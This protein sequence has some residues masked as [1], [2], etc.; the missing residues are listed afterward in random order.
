MDEYE[1]LATGGYGSV[2]LN[3]ELQIV[4]K[5][6]PK[7]TDSNG[8]QILLYSTIV[9]LA[10]HESLS[11]I[12][13]VPTLSS[14]DTTN[15]SVELY[16]PFYGVPLNQYLQS[17]PANRRESF[18]VDII[19]Q[20]VD[21]CIQLHENGLQHTDLKPANI[22]VNNSEIV[23][24]IDFNIVSTLI[25]SETG[26]LRW[27]ESIGTWNYTAPEIILASKPH[28]TSIVWTIGLLIAVIVERFPVK[29]TY[30]TTKEQIHAR[31]HWASVYDAIKK[32]SPEYLP[33]QSYQ[34]PRRMTQTLEFI[35]SR[36]VQWD[37]NERLTLTALRS[38]LYTYLQGFVPP[39]Y[40]HIVSWT[41]DP[42]FMEPTERKHAIWKLFDACT[43][44]KKQ[45]LFVR[46]VS[47]LD[48][49]R[50]AHITPLT[51]CALFV[52]GWLL[53]GEYV[54]DDERLCNK[55]FYHFDIDDMYTL[56]DLM[57]ETW[58][59]GEQLGWRLFEKSTDV[60]MLEY[61]KR[62]VLPDICDYLVNMNVPYTM[63][64]LATGI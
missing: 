39:L 13:G 19:L 10:A 40:T 24:V 49:L 56:Q 29:K 26:S 21:T 22:L 44:C 47:W 52:L 9:D 33:I 54:F 62:H 41:C 14:Y 11:C 60:Y 35:Y 23:T 31:K 27:S 20:V 48:R 6:Q 51:L 38:M 17:V 16:M 30:F 43:L 50:T 15:S 34:T 37:P 8:E 45:S 28:D 4:K 64:D 2:F 25:H 57:N 61:G 3:K 55:M 18:C 58:C 36:C 5:T 46:S 53:Q 59:V 7:Y 12:P 63:Q 1:P 42:S 32:E